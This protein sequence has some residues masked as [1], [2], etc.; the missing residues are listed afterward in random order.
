MNKEYLRG[1]SRHVLRVDKLN[2][3]MRVSKSGETEAVAHHVSETSILELHALPAML[4]FL[5]PLL[6]LCL[7]PPQKHI[8]L[9]LELGHES[10][11]VWGIGSS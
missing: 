8:K 11:G 2:P 9:D 5:C 4:C 3:E 6:L 7:K 1:Q 10:S